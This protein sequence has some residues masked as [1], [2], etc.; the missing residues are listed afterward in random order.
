MWL[1]GD[2]AVYQS[3]GLSYAVKGIYVAHATLFAFHLVV[4]L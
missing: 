1:V 2:I 3:V 4:L